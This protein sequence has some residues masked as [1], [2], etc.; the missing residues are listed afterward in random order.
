[1]RDATVGIALA[2][3]VLA[4]AD[5]RSGPSLKE[6]MAAQAAASP[7]ATTMTAFVSVAAICVDTAE[8]AA[9]RCARG[10]ATRSG[11]TII[12][13]LTNVGAAKRVDNPAEGDAYRR[14]Y[15]A[16]RFGG[17]NGTPAFHILDVRNYEGGAIELI[18]AATGDSL[19]VR[20][21]PILSPDGAR[22]VALEEP[23][24][25]ELATQ[26]DV[27]RVTGDKPVR[28]YTLQPFDCTSD[29]GWGPSDV[30]WR[31]RDTLSFLRNTLPADSVRRMN[32]ER[33]TTRAL[34]VRVAGA[35]MLDTSK[36]AARTQTPP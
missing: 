7:G 27:W 4:C 35:W 21:V 13:R 6:R 23:D 9:M 22:F 29:Q 12:I 32:D 16:G 25:C 26:L 2:L 28:E 24:A 36:A 31:A 30:T 33:D 1:V 3:A 14:Y 34:L 10:V 20:G 5:T 17:D 19:V 15:Y 8:A 11:D 18:N